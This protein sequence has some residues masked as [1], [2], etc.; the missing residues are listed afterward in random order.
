MT[1][2][3]LT[4]AQQKG[5]SGKTTLAVNIAMAF[6]ARGDRVALVDIDPQGSLGQWYMARRDRLG[7]E[8]GLTFGTSSAWGVSFECEKLTRDHDWV[9]VDT[10]PKIDA[11]LRPALR[12]SDLVVVPL[13]VS[14][15]DLWAT[16]GVLDLAAREECAT[17]L[18]MNRAAPRARLTAQVEEAMADLNAPRAD[19]IL[20]NRVL[21][22]ETLGGGSSVIEAR[23]SSPAA[24]EVTALTD[25]ISAHF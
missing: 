9:V 24:A 6:R 18:V 11:G 25:E 12:A 17:L 14:H 4:I 23:R 7:E 15:V 5:G 10:P 22:A 16:R 21:F 19:T 3:V 1:G 20:C 2:R 8:E 13:A